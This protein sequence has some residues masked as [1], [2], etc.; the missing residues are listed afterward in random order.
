MK[1]RVTREALDRM[2]AG[3]S[4]AG[5]EECCG[6]LLGDGAVEEARPAANHAAD[7]HRGFEIDP[8]ALVEAH[9]AARAGGLAVIGYYHSHPAGPAT[10]SE[11]DRAMAPGDGRVWAIIAGGEV[12]FWRDEPDGFAPLPYAVE[13]R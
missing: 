1:L 2:R 10:P 9:R 11:R 5:E 8:Q 4:A 13:D 7:R 12:T 3:A 6:I